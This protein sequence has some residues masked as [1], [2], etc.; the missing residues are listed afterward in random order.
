MKRYRISFLLLILLAFSTCVTYRVE[1]AETA[2]IHLDSLIN[3]PVSQ[4][5]EK[6]I[7]P[8]RD[9]VNTDMN[10]VLCQSSEALYGGKPESPLTNYCADLV[11]EESNRFCAEKY[12]KMKID[13]SII[14]RGGLRIPLPKGE[15]KTM[16]MF[17]LMP[18]ENE[19]VFLKLP[20]D[21]MLEFINHLAARGGEGVSGLRFGIKED[22]AVQPEIEG[23]PINAT[24]SYWLVTSDYI[25]DGGD[26][27]EILAKSTERINTG[28][29]ARDM[30]IQYFKR[31]GKEGKTVTAKTD[32]RIYD[33]K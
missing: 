31:L 17:E 12:P 9:K 29:K 1:K 33:A 4:K 20:G 25:A 27:S 21:L 2:N 30:F 22:K 11:L 3:L 16:T 19:I 32:G 28:I 23:K 14:N 8:Y 24:Q 5:V 18:F 10:E 7:K 13:V 26:G 6:M 15:I